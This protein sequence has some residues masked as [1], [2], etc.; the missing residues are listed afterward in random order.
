MLQPIS[1]V[2]LNARTWCARRTN[3]KC[4]CC[5][6]EIKVVLCVDLYCCLLPVLSLAHLP[7]RLFDRNLL[8]PK[9]AISLIWMIDMFQR[10]QK[11]RKVCHHDTMQRQSIGCVRCLLGMLPFQLRLQTNSL[12][13]MVLLFI[14][15]KH[16]YWV[17]WWS[18]FIWSSFRQTFCLLFQWVC[19]QLYLLRLLLSWGSCRLQL[20][21]KSSVLQVTVFGFA[22]QNDGS[23][24]AFCGVM[25]CLVWGKKC[26]A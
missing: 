16:T 18:T 2:A 22:V 12:A 26:L 24:Q 6:Q 15:P 5:K 20:V 8:V 9:E 4:M 21:A 19:F 11:L 13:C 14:S 3:P 1:R 23:V 25:S 17:K 7:L 10:Q